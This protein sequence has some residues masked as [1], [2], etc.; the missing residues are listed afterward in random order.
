MFTRRDLV[1]LLVPLMI[2]QILAVLVGMADVVMVAVV[3]KRL[4]RACLWWT[5]SVF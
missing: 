4:F 1:R 2:E 5:P 3:G